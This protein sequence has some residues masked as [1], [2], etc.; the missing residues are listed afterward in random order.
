MINLYEIPKLLAEQLNSAIWRLK[1]GLSI[2]AAELNFCAEM[3]YLHN[4]DYRKI[5]LEIESY[6]NWEKNERWKK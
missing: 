2:S 5:E 3:Y 6:Q 1:M 4:E